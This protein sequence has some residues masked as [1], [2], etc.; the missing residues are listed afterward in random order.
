M[1]VDFHQKLAALKLILKDLEPD[2]DVKT[3]AAEDTKFGLVDS[4]LFSKSKIDD[5]GV[6]TNIKLI[7]TTFNSMKDVIETLKNR[8]YE[9]NN[10]TVI[11]FKPVNDK[12]YFIFLRELKLNKD[13]IDKYL[14]LI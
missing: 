2:F 1:V 10:K 12:Y 14:L 7:T 6:C 4:F 3:L 9:F 11:S 5:N 13:N 8:P